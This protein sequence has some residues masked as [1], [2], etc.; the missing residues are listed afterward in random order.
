M[1][2]TR[3]GDITTDD[4]A[5]MLP[6]LFVIMIGI[7]VICFF[8]IKSKDAENDSKPVMGMR[9]KVIEKRGDQ[10][11]GVPIVIAVL[12]Q[13]EDG[14]R[15]ELSCSAK[16]KYVVGDEGFLRWQG[17]RLISFDRER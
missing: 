6:M 1:F 2:L 3:L 7:C 4:I 11:P 5:G 10:G 12:F 13:T 15:I 9:A 14:N 16:N 17:T 8:I